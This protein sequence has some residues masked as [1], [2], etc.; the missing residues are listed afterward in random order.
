MP[1]CTIGV[2]CAKAKL[3]LA[4]EPKHAAGAQQP[5]AVETLGRQL[6]QLDSVATCFA[7]LCCNM[8]FRCNMGEWRRS[9]ISLTSSIF[10]FPSVIESSRKI[11]SYLPRVRTVQTVAVVYS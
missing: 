1:L 3:R 9:A 11:D 5:V 2:R 4:N 8:L 7:V 6:D 10:C